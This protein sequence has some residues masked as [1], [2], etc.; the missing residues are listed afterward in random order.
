MFR[1]VGKPRLRVTSV[2]HQTTS[3]PS[4]IAWLVGC[5]LNLWDTVSCSVR[6]PAPGRQRLPG[7]GETL[8]HRVHSERPQADAGG[9]GPGPALHHPHRQLLRQQGGETLNLVLRV[10]FVRPGLSSNCSLKR[11][12]IKDVDPVHRH[13]SLCAHPGESRAAGSGSRG[14]AVCPRRW[15]G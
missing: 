6:F 1:S 10:V 14:A 7:N 13:P 9:E 3:P 5:W 8:R 4:I 11:V 15:G 12:V 2:M